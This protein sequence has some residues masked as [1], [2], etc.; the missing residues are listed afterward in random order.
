[1][2]LARGFLNQNETRFHLHVFQV[3]NCFK[4][5]SF[6]HVGP[7]AGMRDACPVVY[8]KNDWFARV[9]ATKN[10]YLYNLDELQEVV[11]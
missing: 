5:G 9:F 10:Q 8:T 4:P 6:Q 2:I 1:M 11:G 3:C 7:L